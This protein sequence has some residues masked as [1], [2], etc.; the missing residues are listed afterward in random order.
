M[1]PPGRPLIALIALMVFVGGC[2]L[3][4]ASAAPSTEALSLDGTVW[5]AISV[6]GRVPPADDPPTVGFTDGRIEGSNGCNSY[7][8]D[9]RFEEGRLVVGEIAQTL[10]LCDDERNTIETA[11]GEIL[12]GNPRVGVAERRLVLASEAGEIIFEPLP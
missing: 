4:G 5:R 12:R 8:G 6:G 11:F 3:L 9:A 10:M 7:G 1:L 2:S